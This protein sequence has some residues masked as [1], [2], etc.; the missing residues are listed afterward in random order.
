VLT[1]IPINE[2]MTVPEKITTIPTRQAKTNK[3]DS[4][5]RVSD[6]FIKPPKVD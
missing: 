4:L 1:A 5:A 2:P 6:I 3:L